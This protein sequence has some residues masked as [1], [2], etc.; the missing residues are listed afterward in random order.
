[1]ETARLLP[2]IAASFAALLS[3]NCAPP[4]NQGVVQ[5]T[6]DPYKSE[7]AFRGP[8]VMLEQD[9]SLLGFSMGTG[10][11]CLLR[12]WRNKATGAVTNQLYMII[13]YD[14]SEWRYYRSATLK[15]GVPLPFISID[16]EARDCSDGICL[17]EE[18]FAVALSEAQLIALA[19]TGVSVE[20][21]AGKDDI[22][23]V[24]PEYVRNYLSTV[25]GG[26]ATE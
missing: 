15:G 9:R 3:M 4:A 17:F 18:D 26:P 8:E 14:G 22:F 13:T 12:G 16:R 2:V 7:T 10:K 25:G 1:V 20:S 23:S 19:P 21:R 5:V 11:E 24:S 6:N